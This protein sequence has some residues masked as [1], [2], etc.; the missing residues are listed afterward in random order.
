MNGHGASNG[1]ASS[2]SPAKGSKAPSAA[3][4]KAAAPP[5]APAAKAA[6][7][8]LAAAL[9]LLLALAAG[10][11][12]ALAP[13]KLKSVTKLGPGAF[14]G[15]DIKLSGGHTGVAMVGFTA[16]SCSECKKF[17]R[18]LKQA[19]AQGLLERL[20][21][22]SLKVGKVDCDKHDELCT[23]FGVTGDDAD[24]TGTPQLLWFRNGTFVGAYEGELDAKAI[25]AWAAQK[26]SAEAAA[27]A[28]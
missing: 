10:A 26:G 3:K 11:Y 6:P 17:N 8:T 13:G 27:G 18:V 9:V 12:T 21:G 2:K 1:H 28:E 14:D 5:S 23:R 19:A 20:Q 7:S 22:Q 24:A 15:L 4:A 16:K 25:K